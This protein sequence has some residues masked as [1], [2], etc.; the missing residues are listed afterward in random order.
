M[1]LIYRFLESV[2]R[3]VVE[4]MQTLVGWE[5][6]GQTALQ[7]EP[8]FL[9]EEVAEATGPE[10]DA[11]AEAGQ[12]V[13]EVAFLAVPAEE[14]GK[15]IPAEIQPKILEVVQVEMLVQKELA[16]V[17]QETPVGQQTVV[18]LAVMGLVV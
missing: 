8:R 15:A 14:V 18:A 16:E 5:G 2:V 3:E 6:V 7:A 17:A 9:L 13:K 4:E 12:E 11:V 1:V 10:V